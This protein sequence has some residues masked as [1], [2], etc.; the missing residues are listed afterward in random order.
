MCPILLLLVSFGARALVSPESVSGHQEPKPYAAYTGRA[1]ILTRPCGDSDRHKDW[2]NIAC[3]C[4]DQVSPASH[5]LRGKP[6]GGCWVM[7]HCTPWWANLLV[8]AVAECAVG[9]GS[10]WGEAGRRWHDLKEL[11]PPIPH[12]SRCFLTTMI[13]QLFLPGRSAMLFL[14]WSYQPWIQP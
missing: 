9:R 8:N 3:Y 13:K 5:V 4:L 12:F 6:S 2:R 1:C 11:T 7:G 14:C 10:W